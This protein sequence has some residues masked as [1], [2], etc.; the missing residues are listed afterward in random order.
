MSKFK[1][2]KPL[3]REDAL[4][5]FKLTSYCL[6]VGDHK[7]TRLRQAF[8]LHLV[9][10]IKTTLNTYWGGGGGT[11]LHATTWRL[12]IWWCVFESRSFEQAQIF[13]HISLVQLKAYRWKHCSHGCHWQLLCILNNKYINLNIF[14]RLLEARNGDIIT[15]MD[16]G[17]WPLVRTQYEGEV[18]GSQETIE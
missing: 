11:R 5:S 7:C 6:H 17:T 3:V 2:L 12:T 8:T 16:M 15:T 10:G 1:G 13:L 4:F 14:A 18:R 9:H